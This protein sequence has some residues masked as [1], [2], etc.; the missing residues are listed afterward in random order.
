MKF[1]P[2]LIFIKKGLIF[3]IRF[4]VILKTSLLFATTPLMPQ[5]PY[6]DDSFNKIK[7]YYN[8]SAGLPSYQLIS[9]TEVVYETYKIQ[10][11]KLAINNF[12]DAVF[13]LKLPLVFNKPLPAVVLFS[14]YQT[15]AQAIQLVE[16]LDSVVYVGFEYPWPM[17][18]TLNSMKWNWKRIEVIP[19]L[20]AI[21]LT[22]LSQSEII[23]HQKINVV[24]VSFGNLFFPLAQRILN[25]QDIKMKAIIFGYGGVEISEVI[26]NQLK[27]KI[28]A[29]ELEMAKVIIQNQTW[30]FEPKYHLPYL[31]G[32]FLVVNGTEDEVFP[33]SSQQ[34]LIKNLSFTPK[35]ITLPGG[36]IQPDRTAIIKNFMNE[37]IKFL[38]EHNAI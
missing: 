12:P 19:V 31:K 22:W 33:R 17:D 26:G 11:I 30:I 37:V 18:V 34:D 25:E 24:N 36:H 35:I 10:T 27:D 28:S 16:N 3:I 9:R 14:G 6:S 23:D 4:F 2:K 7:D 5:D 21:T 20:M 38:K 15:G 13:V 32:D 29:F 1:F 8:I